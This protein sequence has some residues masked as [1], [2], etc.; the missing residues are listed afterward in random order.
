MLGLDAHVTYGEALLFREDLDAVFS[1]AVLHW[2]RH[3]DAMI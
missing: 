2:T 1:N 3:A